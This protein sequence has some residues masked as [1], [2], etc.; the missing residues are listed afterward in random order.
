MSEQE[1]ARR[2]VIQRAMYVAPSCVNL[3]GHS[4]ICL[5]RVRGGVSSAGCRLRELMG[6]RREH[7]Q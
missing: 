3:G 6:H 5:S 4:R 7:R 2:E 1:I